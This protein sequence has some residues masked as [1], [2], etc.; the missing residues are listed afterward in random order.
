MAEQ[1]A[2]RLG[3]A[4]G[5]ELQAIHAG[6]DCTGDA[7][8]TVKRILAEGAVPTVLIDDAIIGTEQIGL[9]G[10]GHIDDL[11]GV[12]ADRRHQRPSRAVARAVL[13]TESAT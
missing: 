7:L 9:A 11:R 3:R 1:V 10:R 2:R 5:V 4:G 8:E 13:R 12:P 6:S